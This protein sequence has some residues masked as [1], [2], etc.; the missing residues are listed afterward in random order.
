MAA[1]KPGEKFLYQGALV[2][3]LRLVDLDQIEVDDL[4][5]N[6]FTV[7]RRAL[8]QIPEDSQVKRSEEIFAL[9]EKDMDLATKRYNI[10]SPMIASPGDGAVVKQIAKD[11][12]TP[13][14]T[15]YRWANIFR[16][17]GGAIESLAEGRGK[18]L[19]GRKLL[20]EVLEEI[21]SNAI[22]TKY[23]T[24]TRKSITK[25]IEEV[26][27]QCKRK[28]LTPPHSN[29]I[30]SRIHDMDERDVMGKRKG[31][32]KAED[33]YGGR[34]GEFPDPIH[35]LQVVQIDHTP[36]DIIV[37]DPVHHL[38]IK[39]RPI[40]TTALDVVTRM[41]VGYYLSFIHNGFT[42]AGLCVAH[43]I[44]GKDG[45][46]ARLK[47]P[48]D[49]PCWGKMAVLYMDNAKEFRGHS[50]SRAC[51]KFLIHTEWR[52]RKN[53]RYGGHIESFQKTLNSEI[54]NLPGSTF[55]NTKHR[56]NYD[57]EKMASLT[58][59]DLEAYIVNFIV[60]KYHIR[61]HPKL[62]RPP[63]AAW[64]EQ[65]V[66]DGDKLPG[67]GYQEVRDEEQVK[68]AFL[69]SFIRTIQNYGVSHEG[70]T[71]YS[72]SLKPF[73]KRQERGRGKKLKEYEFRWDPRDL[74][75]IY[76]L[77]PIKKEFEKID[78]AKI[79]YRHVKANIWEYKAM[80]RALKD[81][82]IKEVDEDR[83]FQALITANEIE[84]KAIERK[85]QVKR[86]QKKAKKQ[87]SENKTTKKS[88]AK[89]VDEDDPFAGMD[90]DSIKPY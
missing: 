21:V 86:D 64:K 81:K 11:H 59:D 79:Q 50:M 48:G 8:T 16:E 65:I 78:L 47:L 25:V 27:L 31:K 18:Q 55:F 66:G 33:V 76:L 15:L 4:S 69:P 42:R 24:P 23:L 62:H 56:D 2:R 29:T 46:L 84:E 37:V 7:S 14:T 38:P 43:A 51:S 83:I 85:A 80:M 60:N 87:N 73:I 28:K 10:I 19:D 89:P 30:R 3:V 75:H 58:F 68:I 57:S 26:A 67:I 1:I 6:K 61:V 82:G 63:I 34:P 35:A 12:K 71:Y 45:T 5:K 41:I 17:A 70:I 13:I 32:R 40:L 49:W 22:E 77:H 9:S 20:D 53:P 39:G 52:P 44:L 74:S 88:E 36:V 90:L 54:H 72:N